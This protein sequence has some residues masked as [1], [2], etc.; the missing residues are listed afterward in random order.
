[1]SKA[2]IW[3]VGTGIM[4]IDYAK[5]LKALNKEFIVIGRGE[6]NAVAFKE[7]TG[8]EPIVGGIEKAITT[9]KEL[10]DHVINSVGIDK[11]KEVNEVLFGLGI[12]NQL[13]EKP[14]IAYADEIYELNELATKNKINAL[15][16]Y[17]RR[18]YTAVIEA[19]KIIKQDGG[20]QSFNF[21]FTEWS[22]SIEGIRH[23]K[24][25]AELGNWFLGNS[26]HV[27]DLAFYLGGQPKEIKSF[28]S[29]KNVIDWHKASS[30]FSG[31]GISD[32]GALFSYH[33]NWKSPGRF[34]VEILTNKHRLVFRPLEKL[35]IQNIGSVAINMV[36]G[37]D[38]SLDENFK[39]G[40]FLQTKTFLENDFSEF[41]T[42]EEQAKK[43][44]MYKSMSNY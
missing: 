39:P 18:F 17:N 12:K 9:I 34:N 24:T 21:E 1:M 2:K 33:A 11:L 36:E 35:Q 27:I 4:A 41:C 29:G 42:L 37:I 13:I 40:L 23:L 14:G 8:I 20:V 5:V 10:P 7:A 16:A 19:K 3:L 22:H 38:Y 15:L 6:K 28:V 43:M 26:T 31:A 30:N 32:S 25:D 44:E